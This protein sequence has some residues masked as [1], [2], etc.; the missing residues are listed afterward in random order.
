MSAR[1]LLVKSLPCLACEIQQCSQPNGT[2]E[3]HL[4]SGGKRRGDDYSIPLCK[5]HHRSETR[6]GHSTLYM[7]N[8]YGPSLAKGSKPF[9]ERY[10]TDEELLAITNENLGV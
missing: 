5:W 2:E 7:T 9:H 1:S 3:H 8:K 4:L 10:G 6:W